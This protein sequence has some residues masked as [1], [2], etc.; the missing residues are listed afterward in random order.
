MKAI[1]LFQVPQGV[2]MRACMCV[3]GCMR[4]CVGGWM[5][6]SVSLCLGVVELGHIRRYSR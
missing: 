2:C 3:G 1:F 5:A 4:E 6:V